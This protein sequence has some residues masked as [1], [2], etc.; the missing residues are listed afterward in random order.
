MDCNI[1]IAKLL[2][3]IVIS[4][5]ILGET[6]KAASE[7]LRLLSGSG[8]QSMLLGSSSIADSNLDFVFHI[9]NKPLDLYCSVP[10]VFDSSDIFREAVA[11]GD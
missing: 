10:S 9:F 1:G 5:K 7:V 11:N 4:N 6:D 3:R 2:L 8:W